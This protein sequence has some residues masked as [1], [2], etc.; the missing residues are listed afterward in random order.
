MTVKTSNYLKFLTS[1]V[2]IF[3]L[4]IIYFSENSNAEE[5]S[6]VEENI[7]HTVI[8]V[9]LDNNLSLNPLNDTLIEP[10]NGYTVIEVDKPIK[11][12]GYLSNK[13]LNDMKDRQSKQMAILDIIEAAAIPTG[14]G[15]S[16][17]V[18]KAFNS[19]PTK[20]A[21]A[22]LTG[23]HAY[24]VTVY[25]SGVAPSL[26]VITYIYYTKQTLRFVYQP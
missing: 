21:E 10:F 15:V 23:D 22:A 5:N 12:Q 25:A 18:A 26:S 3:L 9:D 1:F 24:V 13:V 14:G 17:A 8:E 6:Y 11:H 20:L 19:G 7:T 16:I 2:T 4:S